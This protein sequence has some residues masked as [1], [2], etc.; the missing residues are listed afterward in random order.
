[1]GLL[2]NVFVFWFVSIVFVYFIHHVMECQGCTCHG[3]LHVGAKYQYC[4]PQ[5]GI[6]NA[7]GEYSECSQSCGGGSQT[8]TRECSC[9]EHFFALPARDS[10]ACNT[11]CLNGGTFTGDR[12]YC[13]HLHHGSCCEC[14]KCV[15]KRKSSLALKPL[16]N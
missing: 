12:C 4:D 11:F 1:M 14:K 7:W 10:K 6:W 2:L 5:C 9:R 16:F 3:Y 8:R 13:G 15:V